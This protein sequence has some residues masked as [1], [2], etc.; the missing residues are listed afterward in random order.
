MTFSIINLAGERALVQGTDAYGNTG[1]AMVSA[2]E[3]AQLKTEQKHQELHEEFDAK[4]KE[5]FAPLTDAIE[6]LETAHTAVNTDPLFYIVEQEATPAV[7]GQAEKLRR[8]DRDS[9]ILRLIEQDADT[10]RLIWIDEHTLEIL[11]ADAVVPTA[12]P[13]Q[14][15]A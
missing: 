9:V 3:W 12:A 7:E 13:E 4:V 10:S 8:L 2:Y 5:F 14:V 6:Q 15:S 1:K 11:A